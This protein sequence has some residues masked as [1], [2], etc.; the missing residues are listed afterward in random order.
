M[1]PA[2]APFIAAEQLMAQSIGVRGTL[3][4]NNVKYAARIYTERGTAFQEQGGSLQT[5]KLS[6]LV[7]CSLLPAAQL[8]DGDGNTRPIDVTHFETNLVYRINTS[9]VNQSP[10]GVY[11]TLE[12]TQPTAR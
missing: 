2:D 7:L 1:N 6:A 11:W 4:I 9:G 5:R 10:Y 3:V 12:C 8:I